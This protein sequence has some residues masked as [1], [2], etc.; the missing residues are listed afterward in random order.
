M[1]WKEVKDGTPTGVWYWVLQD[2]L[3]TAIEYTEPLR[4]ELISQDALQQND[5]HQFDLHFIEQIIHDIDNYLLEAIAFIKN[6]LE[7]DP[8]S[9]GITEDEIGKYQDLSL[10]D[11]PVEF[12]NITFSTNKIWL[13]RFADADFPGITYGQGIGVFFDEYKITKIKIFPA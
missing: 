2:E 1:N 6:K 11:F 12:P 5:L 10:S 4:V 8:S 13:I 7:D 9:F 3:K